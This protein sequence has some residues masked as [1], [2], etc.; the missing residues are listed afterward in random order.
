METTSIV[1][2]ATKKMQFNKPLKCA[3]RSIWVKYLK[4]ITL[5]DFLCF[6]FCLFCFVCLFVVV[7]FCFGYSLVSSVLAYHPFKN[8]S[9]EWDIWK[10]YTFLYDKWRMKT[11]ICQWFILTEDVTWYP[12]LVCMHEMKMFEIER[13]VLLSPRKSHGGNTSRR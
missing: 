6:I 3:D 7:L 9:P 8:V 11:L 12:Q 2:T 5:S 13:R 4:K 10:A 1:G